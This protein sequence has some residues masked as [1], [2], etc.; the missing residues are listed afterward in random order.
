MTFLTASHFG[1]A[2]FRQGQLSAMQQVLDGHD[3]LYVA[4][5][6]AGKSFIWLAL[7][8]HFECQVVVTSNV[9]LIDDQ[10]RKARKYGIDAVGIHGG[11]KGSVATQAK[12]IIANPPKLIVT[13]PDSFPYLGGMD[14]IKVVYIDEA[15]SIVV[16]GCFRNAY[17][18]LKIRSPYSYKSITFKGLPKAQVVLLSATFPANLQRD[19]F[20]QLGLSQSKIKV[21]KESLRKDNLR[22]EL[23]HRGQYSY[24]NKQFIHQMTTE[25]VRRFGTSATGI[26]YVP[27]IGVSDTIVD[28]FL[29]LGV[30]AETYNAKVN[31]KEGILQRWQSGE[32]KVVIATSAFGQG[33]DND[34]TKWVI[35]IAPE[36]SVIKLYQQG[37]RAGRQEGQESNW[38]I[39]RGLYNPP[40]DMCNDYEQYY[41]KNGT[42]MQS[43]EEMRQV[44]RLL[45]SNHCLKDGL[46]RALNDDLG[47]GTC[48]EKGDDVPCSICSL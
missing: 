33:I 22:I 15:H 48:L 9:A 12:R 6:A 38:I 47:Q 26:V 40:K 43:R 13:T 17:K 16:D 44:Q 20:I 29:S 23:K 2:S 32:T 36:N 46:A 4:K 19:V 14:C 28:T 24:F 30:S 21:V 18:S 45:E 39:Y 31:D 11:L 41:K 5:P 35:H 8:E 3:V 37:T 10:V 1:F 42:S 25:T 34:K 27:W 7:T